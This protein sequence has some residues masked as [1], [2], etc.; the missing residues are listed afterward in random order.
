[1]ANLLGDTHLNSEQETYVQDVKHAADVL[2]GLISDIL[3]LSKIE[4][5]QMEVV[6]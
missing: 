1:M 2:H 5:G 6:I 4:A 3:D